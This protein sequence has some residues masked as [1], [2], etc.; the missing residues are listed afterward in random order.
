M[1]LSRRTGILLIIAGLLLVTLSVTADWI[2]AGGAPEAAE[3]GPLQILVLSVGLAMALGGFVFAL[4]LLDAEAT[5]ATIMSPPAAIAVALS[6]LVLVLL[7][8]L[9]FSS[10]GRDDS[11]ISYWPAQTLAHD[12]KMVNFNGDRVEQSSSLL[13]VLILAGLHTLT[14]I[15]VPVLGPIVSILSGTAAVALAYILARRLHP[16]A[17]FLAALL[18]AL[19]AYVVYWSLSGMEGPLAAALALA[20]VLAYAQLLTSERVTWR[21]RLGVTAATAAFVLVRPEMPIVLAALLA[22]L[23]AITLLRGAATGQ[24]SAVLRRVG[25]LWLVGGL[26]IAAAL[27]FRLLYFGAPFPQPVSVKAG[28]SIVRAIEPGLLYVRKEFWRNTPLRLRTVALALAF[29]CSLWKIFRARQLD[30]YLLLTTL[31]AAV[32]TLFPVAVGGDW[33]EGARFY[34][35]VLPALFVLLATA[36]ADLIRSR[37][38]LSG[39]FA[40]L[41]L[42]QVLIFKP[43]AEDWSMGMPLW[44]GFNY[45][46]HYAIEQGAGDYSWFDRT[47]RDH[48]RDIPTIYYLDDIVERLATHREGP[49]VIF[50]AQA[51]MVPYYVSLH[52][53]EGQVQIY[54]MVG[55][56]SR[57]FMQCAMEN[58]LSGG[59]ETVWLDVYYEHKSMY[60]SCGIPEPDLV[61]NPIFNENTLAETEA[62]GFEVVYEQRGNIIYESTFFPGIP[63]EIDQYIAVRNDLAPLLAG[64][65]PLQLDMADLMPAPT[66]LVFPDD[67]GGPGEEALPGRPG[68]LH[69]IPADSQ[70]HG[71]EFAGNGARSV[72]EDRSGGH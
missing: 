10:T 52:Q 67:D 50:T 21:L 66:E 30:F 62:V 7:G 5:L 15:A 16:G 24:R 47:N 40:G 12:G 20:L 37:L 26:V 38:Y 48:L 55:L 3:F 46:R 4:E 11:Y 28:G 53:G 33:M 35:P 31:F 49:V 27:G 59:D 56:A 22:G 58:G 60:Q 45:Y 51:G 13:L 32:Y 72:K 18:T 1:S 6:V 8:G 23:S 44:E 63:L 14:G 54:D 2:G 71:V 25:E 43:F 36:V 19:S 29:A 42:V 61:F 68:F 70:V 69:R 41:L 65:Y 34:V 9:L 57:D 64:E 17:A 39:A